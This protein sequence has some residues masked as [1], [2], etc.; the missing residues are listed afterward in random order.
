MKDPRWT[1]VGGLLEAA[2][3]RS[4]HERAAFLDEACAGNETLRLEVDSLLAHESEAGDFLESPA[5][6]VAAALAA[7]DDQTLVGRQLA[8]YRIVG[9]LGV[10]GMGEV[11]RA[12][13]TTLG[14]DVAIKILPAVF[15]TDP[16]R[17][18]RF[19]REAR[20]L[21]AL[22]H[23]HIAAIYGV[24]DV[25]PSTGFGQVAGRA[26]VLELVEGETL[27]ERIATGAIPL[28][29]ALTIARQIADALEAAHQKGI[30]HRDLKPA[31][32][33]ITPQGTVKVLD[34]GLAKA[35][36]TDAAP[37]VSKSP[38]AASGGTRT[39]MILGTAA[40][41]SPE[42]ARG[43]AVDKRADIWAFGCVLYEMI[44]GR[45]AFA[46]ETVSDTLVAILERE[47]I[48]QV[49][50]STTP[51]KVRD[52]LRRCLQKDPQHRLR[53]IG[54]A[55]L[56]IDDAIAAPHPANSDAIAVTR[57]RGWLPLAAAAILVSLIGAG[58][59]WFLWI[60]PPASPTADLAVT[61]DLATTIVPPSASGVAPVG[62]DLATP[63]ISPDGSFITYHDRTRTLRL[64]RLNSDSLEPLQGVD[65]ILTTA[66]TWSGDS[67][68]LIFSD[69]T[70]LKRI[71]VPD[72]APEIIGR[73]PGPFLGGTWS[74]RGTVLFV[75]ILGGGA[76]ASNLY[77]IPPAGGEP[78]QIDVPGLKNYF[79]PRFLPGS[80]DFLV[81]TSPGNEIYLVTW[82]DGKPAEPMLLMK[83][84][85]PIRYT[86]AGGGRILF[87]RDF[88]LY[89]QVLNRT[90]RKLEGDA[91]LVQQ[92]VSG[93]SVSRTGIVAWRP[94]PPPR[95]QVTIFDRKGRAIGTAGPASGFLSLKLSPDERHLLVSSPGE[96]WLLEPNRPGRLRLSHGNISMLW[97]S[98]STHVL[99]PLES[100]IVESPLSESAKGRELARVPG[101]A[102]LEDVSPDGKVVLYTKGAFASEV[103]SVRLDGTPDE[104]VPRPVLQNDEWVWNTRFSPDGRWIVYQVAVAGQ[105]SGIYVQRFPGP[106][107][108]KQVT[109][110][111]EYPVWRKDG[112]EIVY[113]DGNRIWSLP[114]DTSGG[115][116]NPG[117][118]G[119]A[120]LRSPGGWGSGCV[121][122]R[123]LA[124]WIQDL[125]SAGGR[126][127]GLRRDPHQNGLGSMSDERGRSVDAL[128]EDPLGQASR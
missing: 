47:P 102:R 112:K 92:G 6:E 24:E 84:A 10:G 71:R 97:S 57:R 94:G 7:S 65:G 86:P 124:R 64:R 76:S 11:Y 58:L 95:P 33:K 118:S 3:E 44:T 79:S 66:E 51:D 15:T 122:S 101:L 75:T 32:I 41:M 99:V 121:A 18:A 17:R 90:T 37:D 29:E 50:P 12:H 56:D 104:R 80:E 54:D 82:R 81:G 42:Q 59:L 28:G 62:S 34:F 98:N 16:G 91:Q 126:A 4:P 100:T 113:L 106:G 45:V 25:G 88:N 55:R 108:R 61:M 43:M 116:F 2:L 119:A 48:W 23:P 77:M 93:F 85:R 30:V 117:Y 20:V 53:D 89:A 52:L 103:F 38:T 35:T 109:S 49:M 115:E 14:R 63:E 73:L 74:D 46:G 128:V 107:L 120:V 60:R 69:A 87:I 105:Q 83:G 1:S 127:A 78:K 39:G 5:M 27:A 26:L 22:N 68:S 123:H 114:V 70:I 13:D 8:S 21:A 67:K 9:L 31:N 96:S 111:G 72:G 40:Y 125:L 36:S 19:D 110:S